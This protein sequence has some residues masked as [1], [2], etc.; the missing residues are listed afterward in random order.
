MF[1][2][3]SVG[4]DLRV[5]PVFVRLLVLRVFG[6][7]GDGVRLHGMVRE[8]CGQREDRA[9]VDAAAQKEAE[10]DVAHEVSLYRRTELFAQF[11]DELWFTAP[12]LRLR[13]ETGPV[14][15][16]RERAIAPKQH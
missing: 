12:L 11:L 3:E 2:A 13:R 10:R 8:L 5:L 7:K 15:P 9:R 4:D 16:H 14:L 1:G 6:A